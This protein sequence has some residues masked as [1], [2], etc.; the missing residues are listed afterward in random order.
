MVLDFVNAADDIEL[1]QLAQAVRKFSSVELFTKEEEAMEFNRVHFNK[2]AELGLCGMSIEE[3]FG[4]TNMSYLAIASVIFETA[5]M[6]LGPAIY[7]GVHLMVARLVRNFSDASVSGPLQEELASARALGAFCLTESQAGSDAAAIRTR[8]EKDGDNYILTGEKIYISSGGVADLYLVFA[9][10]AEHRS[11][12]ISAFLVPKD[13]AGLSFGKPEKKMG[14]RGDRLSNV[15]FDGCRLPS[16][17]LLG[18][19]GEGYKIALSGLNGGRINIA[20]A[21]CGIAS[22]AI[23]LASQH[24]KE[25]RQFGDLLAKFQGLQFMLADMVMKHR[26]SILVTRDAAQ[27]LDRG[28]TDSFYASVAKCFATDR[29]ME[30]TTDAV[31]L[32]GGA[33]YLQEY[34][35]E[36][37]MRDAKMLQI[38]EGTNQIQRILIAR[39]LLGDAVN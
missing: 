31:Q 9:R 10:T 6:Q 25:R 12:G 32:F 38:V 4:G 24:L 8:A 14:C 22:R 29:A 3:N 21:S 20:A 18:N 16:S 13:T 15:I 1:R 17:A 7:L 26:A 37:L 30:I 19:E 28:I 23:E 34:E 5:R 33:G 2:M 27:N 11:K 39:T 36:R 35:V